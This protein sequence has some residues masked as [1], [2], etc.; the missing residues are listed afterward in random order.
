MQNILSP[1]ADANAFSLSRSLHPEAGEL[2]NARPLDP[3][4]CRA[5]GDGRPEEEAVA[6]RLGNRWATRRRI[7]QV[8][9]ELVRWQRRGG[10]GRRSSP[11]SLSLPYCSIWGVQGLAVL[12][13]LLPAPPGMDVPGRPIPLAER[14][15]P[16]RRVPAAAPRPV[17]SVEEVLGEPARHGRMRTR[18]RTRWRTTT[19][20]TPRGHRLHELVRL[21]GDLRRRRRMQR[22][23][24]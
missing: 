18:R 14:R 10:L 13:R 22:W 16:P 11:P 20:A 1:R 24:P 3:L 6:R 19:S 4:R 17:A 5:G 7:L 23:S 2:A 12:G 9:V 15:I 8:A 21:F